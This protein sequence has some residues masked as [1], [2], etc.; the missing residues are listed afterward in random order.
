MESVQE[1]TCMGHEKSEGWKKKNKRKNEKKKEQ[2][3]EK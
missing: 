2:P 3:K 1:V